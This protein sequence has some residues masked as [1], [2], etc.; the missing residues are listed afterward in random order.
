MDFRLLHDKAELSVSVNYRKNDSCVAERATGSLG[1][2][3]HKQ[4][5]HD[6]EL[7]HRRLQLQVR[8]ASLMQEFQVSVFTLTFRNRTLCDEVEGRW[9]WFRYSGRMRLRGTR[10]TLTRLFT[11]TNQMNQSG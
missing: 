9:H 7:E 3:N 10:S 11:S 2:Q 5:Q 1:E 8:Y 6:H 4:L